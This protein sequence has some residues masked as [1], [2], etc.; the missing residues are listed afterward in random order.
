MDKLTAVLAIST[1]LLWTSA[2]EGVIAQ[3][4]DETLV[5]KL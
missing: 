5:K 2:V 4:L 1:G 3:T